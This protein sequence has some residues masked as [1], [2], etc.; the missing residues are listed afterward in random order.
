[1]TD[2]KT[3]QVSVESG[4]R[5]RKYWLGCNWKCNGSIEFI[6]DS[7][8]NMTND[9]KYNQNHMGKSVITHIFVDF[10]ILPGMLHLPLVQAIVRDGILIGAQNVSAHSEGPYT[11]EV[12]ADHLA[13]YRIES[14]LI[15]HSERR[16]LFNENQ[17]VIN[18]KIKQAW[19]CD[20]NLIYCVG[21]NHEQRDAEQFDEVI[22]DQLSPLKTG[23][24]LNWAKTVIAYE[25]LWAMGTGVIASAD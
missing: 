24:E 12:S 3:V 1:M 14:V 20:L 25:P 4:I 15:G 22:N 2:K 7:I 16:T 10:M 21:E 13:N 19:E 23:I 5:R 17:Q 18:D 8:K 6:K 11:G 9:V